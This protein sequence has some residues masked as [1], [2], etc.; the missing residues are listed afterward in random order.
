MSQSRPTAVETS[1]P[2][3][4]RQRIARAA[5]RLFGQK[6][7]SCTS[8]QDIAEAAE[9]QKSILY[10]YFGSKAGLYQSLCSESLHRLR[11]FLTQALRDAGLPL[12]DLTSGIGQ[13]PADVSCE[14]LLGALAETLIALARD[15]REPM[16]FFLA[17]I[18]APDGDRPPASTHEMEQMTPQLIHYIGHAGILRGELCGD[19]R[20]LE[21]LLLGAVQHSIIRHLRIPEKEPLAVGLGQRLARTVLRG[22]LP[23]TIT[24]QP[25]Q[26]AGLSIEGGES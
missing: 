10:Y 2:Q 17:H 7:Y 15:N 14:K 20:D 24:P 13:L 11:A 8:V 19:P 5:F 9:V 4:A 6:G 1:P 18:F 25:T 22:F 23:P 16:R 12:D 21:R 26:P 3:E